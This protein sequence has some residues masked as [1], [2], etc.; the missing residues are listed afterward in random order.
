MVT[1]DLLNVGPRD[2]Q[3]VQ[4]TGVESGELTDGLLVSRPLLESLA[5][6]H[7]SSPSV[8]PGCLF[9]TTGEIVLCRE[10]EQGPIGQYTRAENA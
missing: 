4:L 9:A 10:S 2:A 7:F 8:R 1:G 3:V 6:A 5:N